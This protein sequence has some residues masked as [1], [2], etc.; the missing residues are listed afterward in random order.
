V[1]LITFA[2]APKV[3]EEAMKMEAELNADLEKRIAGMSD[4]IVKSTF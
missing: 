3:S 1:I 4:F 2:G